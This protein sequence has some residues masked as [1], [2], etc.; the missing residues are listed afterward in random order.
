MSTQDEAIRAIRR[1][2]GQLEPKRTLLPGLLGNGSGL[3]SGSQPNTT[4]VR[5]GNR[6]AQ[7]VWNMSM[8][9]IE[10]LP[11][12]VG[13][14][15]PDYKRMEVLGFD[16]S[17]IF[18]WGNVSGQAGYI[19]LHGN[20]HS[21][22]PS[23]PY[24][25]PVWVQ[26]RMILPLLVRPTSPASMSVRIYD[27]YYP[28][29]T[30][31]KRYA[32]ETL[33]L[34]SYIP[35]S[36]Y[37]IFI[38]LYID[39]ASNTLLVE[40]GTPFLGTPEDVHAQIPT[41]P[42]ASIP[43]CAVALTWSTTEISEDNLF[44]IRLFIN[45]VGMSTLPLFNDNEGDPALLAPNLSALDG[46]S[47][48]PTRRD[49]R[50]NLKIYNSG[51]PSGV[52]AAA[53]MGVSPWASREDHVHNYSPLTDSEWNAKGDL[54]VGQSNDLAA[55][56]SVGTNGQILTADSGETLG[57]KW[58]DP[59][60]VT[61][62]DTDFSGITGLIAHFKASE[63]VTQSGGR[64]SDWDGVA[65]IETATQA[66]AG[67][68]PYLVALAALGWSALWFP[69]Q[70]YMVT[71]VV[72]P[73]A[74]NPRSIVVVIDGATSIK[75]NEL[76]GDNVNTV[77]S[78]GNATIDEAFGLVSRSGGWDTY[79]YDLFDDDFGSDFSPRQGPAVVI[80]TYD[81]DAV[82]IYWNG[83]SHELATGATLA[84]G[85]DEP[86]YIGSRVDADVFSNMMLYE[87]AVF[88]VALDGTARTDILNQCYAKYGGQVGVAP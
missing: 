45:A 32:G 42:V 33:D 76:S 44:D 70:H 48:Y 38:T 30:S 50:H 11:V 46:T 19:P 55:R 54:W 83:L 58:A 74:D 20:T 12:W 57:V 47:I 40:E 35:A 7:E 62:T 18:D 41:P 8:P 34:T 27:D 15:P 66:T 75:I 43:L 53:S 72:G 36:G 80:L 68:R 88:D 4:L 25:D 21:S 3:V 56:L 6:N 52:A 14:A 77:A 49:H 23:A 79:G 2:L 13:Y 85:T 17:R 9:N 16:T 60:A 71:D 26:K 28:Y 51:V 39:G 69:G 65:S 37:G 81:G 67:L 59:G 24:N 10:D 61:P 84:T 22:D 87:L 64:V 82:N 1:A 86:L 73:D 31:W 5:I 63:G 78:Y 29:G